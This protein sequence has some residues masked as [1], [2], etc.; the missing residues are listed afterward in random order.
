MGR[1]R[2][3]SEY[4]P[5]APPEAAAHA[6]AF[7]ACVLSPPLQQAIAAEASS[8]TWSAAWSAGSTSSR[9]LC[10]LIAETLASEDDDGECISN[11]AAGAAIFLGKLC[12][13]SMS[14]RRTAGDNALWRPL[15]AQCF[16]AEAECGFA[17]ELPKRGP[18]MS[19][20]TYGKL[21]RELQANASFYM[22]SLIIE[23]GGRPKCIVH[24]PTAPWELAYRDLTTAERSRVAIWAPR[25]TLIDESH[26]R[27]AAAAAV[28]QQQPPLPH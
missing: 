19:I 12:L 23:R 11:G 4:E 2:N 20:S 7:G 16:G 26:V 27:A 3:S 24:D 10:E 25:F 17:G 28:Q 22:R 1:T 15:V 21:A 9:A 18:Y 14:L 8:K 5:H 13:C 6:T